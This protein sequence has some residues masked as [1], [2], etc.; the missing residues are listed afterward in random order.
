MH[1]DTKTQKPIN[2]LLLFPFIFLNFHCRQI[3]GYHQSS[4]GEYDILNPT[5]LKAPERLATQDLGG[6]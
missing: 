6:W 3:N 5:K 2:Y 4:K 1:V